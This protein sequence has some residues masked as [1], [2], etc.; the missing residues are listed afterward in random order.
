MSLPN[1]KKTETVQ[2]RLTEFDKNRIK[3]LADKYAEGNMTDWILY[4]AINAPRK[5]IGKKA[6]RPT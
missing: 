3:M 6:K 2:L 1:T 4:G 5:F